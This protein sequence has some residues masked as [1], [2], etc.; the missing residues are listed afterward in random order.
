MSLNRMRAALI[1]ILAV[2]AV[3]NVVGTKESS[4]FVQWLSFAFFLGAVFLYGW[5][6]R[7]VVRRRSALQHAKVLD[8]E[9]Q[10]PRSDHETRTGPDQ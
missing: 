8:R 2:A 1:A 6:R 3:L 10:T 9:A 7:E 4:P 5:W